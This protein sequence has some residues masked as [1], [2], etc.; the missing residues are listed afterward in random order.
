MPEQPFDALLRLEERRALALIIV[1]YA[2]GKL[3]QHGQ[4]H[5]DVKPIQHVLARRYYLLGQRTHL[6]AAI[7]EEGDLLIGLQRHCHF[8]FGVVL[9]RRASQRGQSGQIIPGRGRRGP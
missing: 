2:A 8:P 5:S 1:R 9:F 4:V 3:A 6:L 7:G